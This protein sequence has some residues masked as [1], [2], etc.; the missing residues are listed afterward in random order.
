MLKYIG[1]R[2]LQAIPL[3]IIITF[4]CF[5]LINLAPYDAIDAVTTPEMSREEVEAK[6]EAYGLNDPVLVQ[7]GRWLGN[8][9]KGEFGY[10]LLSHT[11]I[12]Y[13]LMIRIPSTIKLV[14][15]SYL[16]AYLLAI[17]LGLIAGSHRNKWQDKLIDGFCSVGLSMPTF[18]F[19]MIV[20]YFLGYKLNLF[21]LLGMHTI[22]LEDSFVD[23][24]RHFAMPYIVLVVGFL[25]DLTRYVRCS[26]IS[27]FKEDYVMVQQAFGAKKMEILFRHVSKNVLIPLLTKLG[28]A[29]PVL[30]TGAV[31][32]ETIFSWPGIGS[33]F[34][35]AISAMDYP[36]IMS[37][38]VLSGTLVILGNLLSDILC[39]LTDPRIK[40]MK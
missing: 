13:D 29:L 23:F 16:T 10:S 32:T 35:K 5:L 3:L 26:T 25:P 11:S 27:Q 37:V 22:G 20:M 31:I 18:W 36:I 12:K 14:L 40:S 7:Y 1:K 15:P 6:R 2:I 8:I 28:M 21:P 34:V 24:L 19:A 4:I 9:V 33:Y 17:V 39:C 30:V 38:L